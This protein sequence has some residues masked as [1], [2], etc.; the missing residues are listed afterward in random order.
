MLNVFRMLGM[1]RGDRVKVESSGSVDVDTIVE[2]GV[3][4]KPD[5]DA[6]ATRSDR[7]IAILAWNY[8]DDDVP[9]PPAPVRHS[10]RR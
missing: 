4:Q 10:R 2:T 1:M 9:G 8:H 3:H 6:L 7:D 5:I